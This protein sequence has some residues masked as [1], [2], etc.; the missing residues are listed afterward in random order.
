MTL[1]T[2]AF[3]R[4]LY[5]QNFENATDP[6]EIGWKTSGTLSIASDDNGKFLE[7][8]QGGGS[9]GRSAT[10][11]WGNEIYTDAQGNSVIEDGK[12]TVY[13]EFCIQTLPN[14]NLDSDI[15]IFTNHAPIDN[16]TYRLPWSK[17]DQVWNNFILDIAEVSANDGNMQVV[18]NAPLKDAEEEG[19]RPVLDTEDQVNL[20]PTKWY[21]ATAVVDTE[22]RE[23]EYSVIEFGDDR[24]TAEGTWTV[25]ETN[26]DGEP[27][28]IYAEGITFEIA[29]ASGVDY[30]DNIKVTCE[31]SQA[32][33]NEPVITLTRLGRTADDVVELKLRAYNISFVEG[34]TLHVAGTDGQE[35]AIDWYDCDGIYVYET[36]TSG[37]LKAWTTIEDAVSPVAETEVECVPVK[38]PNVTATISS[39]KEGVGKTYTLTI[40]NS[41]VLLRPTIFINYEFKGN[42][43]ETLKAEEL[44]SGAKV[45]V[46]QEGTLTL[47]AE[48]FGYEASTVNVVNN[49]IFTEKKSWDFAHMSDAELSAVGFSS[50]NITNSAKQSGF[51]NWTARKRLYYYDINDPKM[52]DDGNP[53]VDDNGNPIYN[54]VYPFGFVSEDS[55]TNVIESSVIED[56]SDNTKYFEG[57]EIFTTDRHVG[58]IKHIGLYNDET[59]NNA[60]PVTI[61]NVASNDFVVVNTI[62]NYGGNSSHP[63]CA[64]TDEYYTQLTGE[65]IVLVAKNIVVDADAIPSL[66]KAERGEGSYSVYNEETGTYDVSYALY[67]VDTAITKLSIF[68]Q[69]GGE[70]AVEGVDAEVAGDNYWYSIDGVRV[71]EPTRPGLYIHNG[72]KIIVK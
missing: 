11:T 19:A 51:D 71:A 68:S 17:T 13:F 33:A 55:E 14:K 22:T 64:T 21:A 38:L 65:D 61:K 9:G 67:R 52:D 34:E 72:K 3:E 5:Q 32:I 47:T 12:Y 27:V 43:G 37:T 20:I 40:S 26:P 1:S 30:I 63:L 66:K 36:T 50:W 42:E 69:V 6:S 39:V 18:V 53:A 49:T 57:L 29:R 2:F 62:D 8:N 24:A 35:T 23:V 28:S 58:M 7:F 70:D 59:V 46:S 48:A 60:N 16:N 56:N 4:I 41:D 25:P 31:S 45:S 10:L 15:T 54:E 44:A